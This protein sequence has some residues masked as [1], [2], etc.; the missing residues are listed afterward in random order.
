MPWYDRL[1]RWTHRHGNKFQAGVCFVT[2]FMVV[3][4]IYSEWIHPLLFGE[5]FVMSLICTYVDPR[6]C[7]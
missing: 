4:G 3:L 7:L 1:D 5:R 6:R 2:A